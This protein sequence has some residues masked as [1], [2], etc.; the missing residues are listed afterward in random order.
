MATSED[1]RRG[2]ERDRAHN[3][4]RRA[5]LAGVA[6]AALD[7]VLGSQVQVSIIADDAHVLAAQLHL[8]VENTN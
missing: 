5:P 2:C 7:D 1:I 3:L 8:H 6:E 4:D